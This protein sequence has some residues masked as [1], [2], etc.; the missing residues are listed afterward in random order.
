MKILFIVKE[1]T[2]HERM[3]IMCLS[4]VLKKLGYK[5][6]LVLLDSKGEQKTKELI[7]SLKPQIIAYSVMTGEHQRMLEFNAVLKKDFDFISV[8]G[9]PHATFFSDLIYQEGVDAVCVGESEEAFPEFC[10]R[11]VEGGEFWKTPNFLCKHKGEVI[12]NPILP[13]IQ[14]LDKLPFSDRS[15]MY[16]AD[17]PLYNDGR[18]MFFAA[19]GCPQKC[20][21]CFN[22]KYNEIYKDKGPV[23]RFR[24]PE[25]IIKEIA[26]VKGRYPLNVVQMM[27]DNF[28]AKPKAWFYKFSKLYKEQVG[29]PFTIN[30]RADFVTDE[31]ILSLKEAGLDS[32]WMGVECGNQE[33]A[34]AILKRG[35]TNEKIEKAA[36]IIHKY[37]LKLI[38]QNLI[39]L[40]VADSY[41]VDLETLDFNIR[42]KPTFGWSSILYPIRVRPL[43]F[44]RERM[45]FLG[46]KCGFL[47]QTRG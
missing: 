43:R 25:N 39:G 9:G 19:R 16:E 14:D 37:K 28:L 12:K 5:A 38:T 40:P 20:A 34:N 21:Y 27:D 35:L 26:E 47:R 7:N 2:M 31:V 24:S 13:L 4:A 32:V 17:P 22:S 11:I 6:S 3:G 15:I 45:A 8:F 30:L 18:K 42:I 33:K 29:L 44:T 41:N 23:V 36:S 46:G 10:K 1:S